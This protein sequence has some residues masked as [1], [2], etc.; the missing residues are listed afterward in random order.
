MENKKR[1]LLG[2]SGGVD[3]AVSAILLQKSGFEVI[4]VTMRLFEDDCCDN[5][6]T[7][8]LNDAKDVCDKLSIKHYV[9]DFRDEF[10]KYVI[11][12]FIKEYKKGRTPNPCIECN[13]Y[14]KFGK[15]YELAK[16]LDC[17]YIATGH[18]AKVEY[19]DKYQS[20]VLKKSQNES[21]DQSYVVYPIDKKILPYVI[22]PLEK[23]ESKDEIRKIAKEN[24]LFVASK[25]DSEDICFIPD[26][27]HVRFLD[28]NIKVKEGKI[29]DLEGKV[30]GKHNG[31]THYTIG[32]R[33]GLGIQNLNPLY[34]VKIKPK[35]N[36]IVV[37]EK[38]SV[39]NKE[40]ILENINILVNNVLSKEGVDVKVKI[41]YKAKEAEAKAYMIDDNV[42][43]VF[44]SPQFAITPGQSCVIYIDDVVIAGGII[45]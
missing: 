34:V 40:V 6:N 38:K 3:S 10:K 32:Q 42:R 43:I 7:N 41:R 35:T 2:M 22:F 29:I 23:F 5:C 25:P 13:R 24:G 18:Y 28:E 17:T 44:E 19:S 20:Y 12:N 16:E 45:K 30:R 1:V 39:L 31:F 21:K 36:E 9:Y 15:M 37:G 4:G 27:N 8:T 14:L 33:K 11:D 26:N